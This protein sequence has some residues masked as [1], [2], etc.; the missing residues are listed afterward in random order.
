MN[1]LSQTEGTV[2]APRRAL[3]VLAAVSVTAR[4]TF[5]AAV[6]VQ[7]AGNAAWLQAL[8]FPLACA[9]GLS[10][11]FYLTG[12]PVP[13]PAQSAVCVLF[14]ILFVSEFSSWLYAAAECAAYTTFSDLPLLA[15]LLPALAI[16]AYI[17]SLGGDALGGLGQV[18][19]AV[20]PWLFLLA[21]VW[22]I[23][24]MRPVYLTPILGGGLHAILRG[25]FLCAGAG[26][27]LPAGLWILWG[28]G[29]EEIPVGER[30]RAACTSP[31]LC[32]LAAA[33]S[34]AILGMLAPNYTGSPRTPT[35]AMEQLLMG[36]G[37]STSVQFPLML[38]WYS[39]LLLGCV[40]SCS[41]AAQS[42]NVLVPRLSLRACSWLSA[43]PCLALIPVW[44]RLGNAR[45]TMLAW[46]W[47]LFTGG[48]I[49]PAFGVW[50]RERRNARRAR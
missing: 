21:T 35:R 20:V 28:A 18:T 4:V 12:R 8:L 43:L 50:I 25:A 19:L 16:A 6:D 37:A 34:L 38:L 46:R 17:S 47:P 31:L 49:L 24:D 36:G 26:L 1:P 32:A 39:L 15:L 9:P 44:M 41:S 23:R 48:L 7:T 30:R 3:I 13:R 42:L 14:F 2:R 45:E 33:G 10:A 40:F 5:S 11:F 27:S 22:Q 29:K